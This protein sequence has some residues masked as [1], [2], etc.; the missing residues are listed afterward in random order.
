MR[1][2]R[3]TGLFQAPAMLRLEDFIGLNHEDPWIYFADDIIRL[4]LESWYDSA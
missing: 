3:S 1:P 2:Q 4:A